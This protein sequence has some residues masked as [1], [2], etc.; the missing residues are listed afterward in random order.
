MKSVGFS[1]G[2]ELGIPQR[3]RNRLARELPGRKGE[4]LV[5]C[6]ADGSEGLG[7]TRYRS[8]AEGQRLEP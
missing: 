4:G 2:L 6:R 5:I 3:L 1:P 8:Y 7:A